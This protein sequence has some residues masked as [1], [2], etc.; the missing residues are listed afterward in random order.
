DGLASVAQVSAG[1]FHTCAVKT[2]GTVVCWGINAYGQTTVP[3][4]LTSVAQVSGV[5]DH[6]CAL[7]T[8][9]T[10][11]CWGNNDSGQATVPDGL[12]LTGN[13]R[14]SINFTSSPPSPAFVGGT[15]EVAATGGA[16]GRPVI[17]SSLT[18]SVC[19]IDRSTVSFIAVGT[20]TIAANQDG[21]LGYD[22]APE[23]TQSFPVERSAPQ[24]ITFT[25]SPPSSALT[26]GTY[27]VSATGGSS[28]NAV[29]F[30]SLTASICTV[31]GSSVS[32]IAV[33]SCTIAADQAAG[34]GYEAAPQ[35]TQNFAIGS[36]AQSI[37]FTSTP[38]SSA[39]TGG[40]YTVAAMGGAS[41]NAVTFSSLTAS[42]CTVSGSSVSL[43][44]VG[45]CTIAADQA[46]GSGY[47]AAPQVTQVFSIA[48]SAQ[49]ITF[50]ST[51]PSPAF[52][53][54][55]YTVAATGGASGN[56]VTF[57]SLTAS[58]CTVSESSVSLIAVGSC[59]VAADQAAGN[60]YDVADQAVQTFIVNSPDQVIAFTSTPPN[61][62]LVGSGYTISATGGTSGNPVT[63]SS[64]TSATCSLSG[65]VVS[66]LQIGTC[67]IDANQAGGAGYN[68]APQV[69]QTITVM[70]TQTLVFTSTPPNPAL[71]GNSY[72][73]AAT[74][75]GSGNPIVL[76]SKTTAVCSVIGR[77]VKLLAAG[78]CVIAANQAAGNGYV[79]APEVTQTFN[80]FTA[81]VIN[82]TSR[83]PNKATV[84]GTYMI[85]A[86]G[87]ASGNPVVFSTLTPGVCSI[88]GSTTQF[89]ASGTCTVAA[90]Q[91]GTATYAP[92][93]QATQSVKIR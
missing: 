35:V 44:A 36:S 10:V 12:N 33:G 56:A 72:N 57:S 87:G 55:A 20:C 68:A 59:T 80:V 40:T 14:Q 22:P 63:F 71:A 54:G 75:G 84:G 23:Q 25:S 38:P 1:L 5:G 90:N 19:R 73:V 86:T 2:D 8:D 34:N 91:S 32:L 31:S 27:N 11:V 93:S 51:P 70:A 30:S 21:G 48:S 74:G 39:L 37:A 76:S 65:S 81:Q 3:A 29:T 92:A 77:A 46:A 28:G 26:G 53:G 18:T 60:G 47:D 61:P 41:G 43:V 62:G 64:L 15:Y 89:L 7:K 9:G 66:F 83:P 49:A 50:T 24:S 79:A 58:I 78:S 42:I 85:T 52:T 88:N 17:F 4:G 6:T 69:S 16:S 82:F 67:T 13:S 45:S